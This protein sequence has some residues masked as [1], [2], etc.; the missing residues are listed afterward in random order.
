MLIQRYHGRLFT[1]GGG[2]EHRRDLP[3]LLPPKLTQRLFAL[4]LLHRK[5]IGLRR[6]LGGSVGRVGV[7]EADDD[8]GFG[9]TSDLVRRAVLD[10]D[11]RQEIRQILAQRCPSNCACPRR[12]HRRSR[13][14][15]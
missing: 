8:A 4:T 9:E 11:R 14:R 12:V 15:K 2:D 13:T 10:R 1:A 7:A 3:S 5:P 6:S